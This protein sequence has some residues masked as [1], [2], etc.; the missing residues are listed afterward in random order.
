MT[1]KLLITLL[2][3]TYTAA[4]GIEITCE[5][6]YFYTCELRCPKPPTQPQSL[7]WQQISIDVCAIQECPNSTDS[8]LQGASDQFCRSCPGKTI[9]SIPAIYANAALTACVP[10]S[11][12]CGNK[13]TPNTWTDADCQACFGSALPYAKPNKDSCSQTQE[14]A[15]VYDAAK[16][17]DI[18][19]ES[20]YFYTCN[21]RCPKPPTLP[22]GL[23]WQQITIDLCA[24]QKCPTS[25]DSG[26]EGASDQFCRSCPGKTINQI[27]AIYA[28]VALTA[29]VPSSATCGSQRPPNTWTDDDCKVCY[30]T[31]QS[32]AKSDKSSCAIKSDKNSFMSNFGKIPLLNL[33]SLIILNLII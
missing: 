12:T 30:G 6:E 23:N 27:P 3:I 7:S 13:R 25:T 4:K 18:T 32:Y 20:E 11:A 16:G 24:I 17:K 33:I 14:Q 22:Q 8:G 5:S 21:L 28:N 26:L 10:S 29:C 9:N 1:L 2:L 15:I 31:A 19:C